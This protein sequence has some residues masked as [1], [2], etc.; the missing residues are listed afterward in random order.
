MKDQYNKSYCNNADKAK[1]K[2]AEKLKTIKDN[3]IVKK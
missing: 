1:D 3:K 2:M